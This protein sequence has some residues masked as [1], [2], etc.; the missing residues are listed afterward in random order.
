[1]TKFLEDF[2]VFWEYFNTI[3]LSEPAA[4]FIKIPEFYDYIDNGTNGMTIRLDYAHFLKD[5]DGTIN[6]DVFKSKIIQSKVLR[7]DL[8]SRDIVDKYFDK[9]KNQG[10]IQRP[11]NSV[12]FGKLLRTFAQYAHNI[13]NLEIYH[14]V[15]T[16][17]YALFL[18]KE[19]IQCLFDIM[20]RC[21]VCIVQGNFEFA[22]TTLLVDMSKFTHMR[23]FE[24]YNAAPKHKIALAMF[25]KMHSLKEMHI[26][27]N[28]T[29]FLLKTPCLE[30]LGLKTR[31]VGFSNKVYN[32]IPS[33]IKHLEIGMYVKDGPFAFDLS[34]FPYLERLYMDIDREPSAKDFNGFIKLH[35]SG[36]CER[37]QHI[38][39]SNMVIFGNLDAPNLYGFS[40][41]HNNVTQEMIKRIPKCIT[42]LALSGGCDERVT[43]DIK[44]YPYL[45]IVKLFD[46]VESKLD[47]VG[48]ARKI[49]ESVYLVKKN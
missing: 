49:I 14:L 7:I 37:L 5:F 13:E 24:L 18:S 9:Y 16:L 6:S 39:I 32:L 31:A 17:K 25:N 10:E 28:V 30:H 35:T 20:K 34:R 36:K 45:A 22:D 46:D 11:L 8:T 26:I 41:K 42:D 2:Y 23:H 19:T 4:P 44:L 29:P 48:N 21:R 15:D 33:S 12:F 27:N 3:M 43:L 47:F 1:M 40:V 38:S